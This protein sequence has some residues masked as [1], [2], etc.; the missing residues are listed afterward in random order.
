MK[1]IKAILPI[2]AAVLALVACEAPESES[3]SSEISAS[4]MDSLVLALDWSPNV[5]H[6]GIILADHMGW[7][8][9]A[10][11]AL[12]WFSTEVDN[13]RKKP[14]QRLV[15]GEVDLAIAPSEHAF[16]F[17]ESGHTR[18]AIAVASLLQRGQSFFC[19][20][21]DPTVSGLGDLSGYTYLGYDTPLEQ[22]ILSS[23][24]EQ[25]GAE[26]EMPMDSPG[27]LQVW[28]AFLEREKQM[29]WIF[30]H[31]EGALAEEAGLDLS[32]YAPAD[33]AVPYGYSSVVLAGFPMDR[34]N[35]DALR[36]FLKVTEEAYRE[37]ITMPRDSLATLLWE[38]TAH[39]N[40]AERDFVIRAIDRIADAYFD[41]ENR[42]GHM[43]EEVWEDYLRWMKESLS[44]DLPDSLHLPRAYFTNEYLN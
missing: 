44:D 4:E 43:E 2:C 7:Y 12:R 16:Y 11:I 34:A 36:R 27:R 15:D 21:A 5:L 3:T 17:R 31:W 13:Y 22:A 39:S 9:D 37:A 8:A 42:W 40:F 19:H 41:G 1:T 6:T 14:V 32:C 25:A 30:S 35:G 24:L 23:M 33:Y 28:D 29:V 26:E 38:A 20:K 18:Q 10:G